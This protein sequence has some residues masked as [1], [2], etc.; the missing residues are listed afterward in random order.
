MRRI[1]GVSVFLCSLLSVGAAEAKVQIAVDLTSQTMH[2]SA[3]GAEYDW[4]VSTARSGYS[5]PRGHYRVGH[6]ERMHYSHKYHMSPMPYSIFFA[7]GYAIHGTYS[8]ADLGRP[9]SHGCVRL[10]PSDAALLYEMVK[11]QGADIRI[12]GAPPGSPIY[13]KSRWEKR[14]ARSRSRPVEEAY[15]GWPPE[16]LAYAPPRHSAA[17]WRA[18]RI[19]EPFMRSD[20]W[21][22]WGQ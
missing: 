5:T 12:F 17:S 8:T 20:S 13:A 6:L 2:V 22:G 3:D 18:R 16:A 11:A 9:A 15:A 4:P 1:V 21:E 10:S 7:G 14:V 19:I